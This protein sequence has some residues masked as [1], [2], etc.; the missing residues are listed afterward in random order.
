MKFRTQN[1][2]KGYCEI[3]W[4]ERDGQWYKRMA[5]IHRHKGGWHWNSTDYHVLPPSAKEPYGT[6]RE[7][8]NDCMRA[9]LKRLVEHVIERQP[10]ESQYWHSPRRDAWHDVRR[11][12][13]L[14]SCAELE[15]MDKRLKTFEEE[16][17]VND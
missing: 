12:D 11:Y 15:E 3:W 1:V 5:V 7:C 4:N 17:H 9:A 16:S 8:V 6:R 10:K 13:Y 2:R 14:F